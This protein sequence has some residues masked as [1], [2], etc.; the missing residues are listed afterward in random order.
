MYI[1]TSYPRLNREAARLISP[2]ISNVDGNCLDFHF[3]MHGLNIRELAVYSQ[4]HTGSRTLLWR[5]TGER[6]DAWYFASV[7]LNVPQ[8]SN[9]KV[10]GETIGDIKAQI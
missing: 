8:D 6:G 7:P 2:Q 5:Q 9:I 10:N 1:E 3:H 4:S